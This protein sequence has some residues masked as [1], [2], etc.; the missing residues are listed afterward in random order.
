[1]TSDKDLSFTT[2][3]V[4]ITIFALAISQGTSEAGEILVVPVL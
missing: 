3:K 2:Y 4:G 1:M